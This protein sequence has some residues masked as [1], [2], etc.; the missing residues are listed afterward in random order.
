MSDTTKIKTPRGE[1][2]F[3]CLNRTNTF[4]GKDTGK[5]TCKIILTG[6]HL[7]EMKKII[8][9][10]LEE[11]YGPKK[12]A[13]VWASDK[14]PIRTKDGK[15]YV[16]FSTNAI[17]KDGRPRKVAI[18]DAK[19]RPVERELDIGSGS[20]IKIDGAIS[21]FPPKDPGVAFYLNAVQVIKLVEYKPGASFDAEDDD[22]AFDADEFDGRASGSSGDKEEPASAHGRGDF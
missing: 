3:P 5:Y 2:Y 14:P 19:G 17:T 15:S 16:N 20:I 12:A 7:E 1:A 4:N 21:V 8:N 10:A 13:A 22:D 9:D 18:F 6:E 11:A